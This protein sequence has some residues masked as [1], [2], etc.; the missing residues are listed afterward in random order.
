MIAAAIYRKPTSNKC[1]EQRKESSPPMCKEDDDPNA[2]W[3]VPMVACMHRVPVD[4]TERGAKWP[5]PW[6]RRLKRAPYWLNS[7]QIGIYGKPT[8]QD[9][10]ADNERWKNVVD[11]LSNLG[12]TWSSVRN[13]MDMR[14][15]YGG[16]VFLRT[17][18]GT[19]SLYRVS[20][21]IYRYFKYVCVCVRAQIC[22][23][24]EGSSCLG[25]QYSERKFSGH[26]SHNIRAWSFWNIP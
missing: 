8:P 14:A 24:S 1:Y 13:V 4:K 9:F 20:D 5:E 21:Q 10:V 16:S 12:I 19:T 11:E 15:V 7:S 26:T 25:I 2:A 22:S 17:S 3:Y 6:P 23:S 18:V